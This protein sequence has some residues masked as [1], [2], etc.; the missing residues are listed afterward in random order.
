MTIPLALTFDDILI[1]PAA[2]NIL[3]TEVSLKT[4]LGRGIILEAPILSAA[5]DTVT[6]GPMALALSR[7]GGM[8]IIHRNL[9]IENQA[10]EVAFVKKE[11]LLVGAAIGVGEGWKDRLDALLKA[12]ADLIIV[13]TAHG[14]SQRVIDAVKEVRDKNPDL[15][16]GAG[17]V[18]TA[19]ATIALAE[20]GADIIK[21]GVGP[22]S[23]CTTRIVTGIGVPQVS[24]ILECVK[25][26]KR[27]GLKIVADGG[28][29]YS[30]DIAK[31]LACGADCVML[32]SL[33]AGTSEAPGDMIVEGEDQ[34]KVYRGMGSMGAMGSGS[35]DRY[36]QMQVNDSTK[37]VA[38]GVE[39]RVAFKGDL[40]PIIY[41][42]LGGVRA[43]M[44]YVG[45]E[46]LQ[47]FHQNAK[48]VQITNAGRQESHVHD[49]EMTKNAPNYAS[50]TK[51]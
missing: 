11:G 23:I 16:I 27:F 21:V 40:E 48:L 1:K 42:L 22:G 49:I 12:K 47:A 35:K 45:A 39:G 19:E 2:S 25:E 17:N 30:G 38:E 41:Q 14:H 46:N 9:P 51:R 33:L 24:A 18:A 50:N 15:L 36:F 6:E 3:P 43:A 4:E 10:E 31:A 5:M 29:R 32:G 8:G 28:I 44:G 37:L 26:A 34:F 13:D 7:L 20:A